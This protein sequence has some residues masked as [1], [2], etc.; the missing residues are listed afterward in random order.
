MPAT[1]CPSILPPN[2]TNRPTQLPTPHGTPKSGMIIPDYNSLNEP[3]LFQ[4]QHK[5][6][7]PPKRGLNGS[8]RN[9]K[10]F[11]SSEDADEEQDRITRENAIMLGKDVVP[12]FFKLRLPSHMDRGG[13]FD[14]LAFATRLRPLL[15]CMCRL[16]G[17]KWHP[18][19][20]GFKKKL[21]I[22][23]RY[24]TIY[25]TI[26][27]ANLHPRIRTFPLPG[28]RRMLPPCIYL[29]C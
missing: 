24:P 18:Q 19:G 28:Y 15:R 25:T 26:S 20:R 23:I 11:S 21:L 9:R 3:N 27:T 5:S 6:F 16:V 17:A 29:L 4:Q 12:H 2:V 7:S 22:V 14:L 1:T 8:I 10:S 13:I